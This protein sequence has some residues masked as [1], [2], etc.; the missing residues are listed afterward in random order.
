MPWPNNHIYTACSN[1]IKVEFALIID[2]LSVMPAPP[3][4]GCIS[5][6]VGPDIFKLELLYK[7]AA[8]T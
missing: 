8:A 2:D 7:D 4:L 3:D 6:D 1:V 5:S